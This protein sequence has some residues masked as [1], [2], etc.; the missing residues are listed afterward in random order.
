MK[1]KISFLH[2]LVML[3]TIILLGCEAFTE[4][5]PPRNEVVSAAVFSS[6]AASQSAVSGIYSSMMNTSGMF[7]ALTEQ[8]TGWSSDELISASALDADNQFYSNAILVTNTSLLSTFWLEPYKYI[9]NANLIIEG[10]GAST[11]VPI[12]TKAQ[13]LAEARFIR[14]LCY[15]SL[16]NLFGDVPLAVGTDYRINASLS[17]TTSSAV[18]DQ[19]VADLK[20]AQADLPVDF[21]FIASERVRPTRW[22]ATALLAR[23]YLYRQN[24]AGAE[25]Q[26]SVVIANTALFALVP[27]VKN[28]F[29]K[30]SVE[31]IWQLKPVVPGA[32]TVQADLFVLTTAP[33]G[34]TR[35]SS[36]SSSLVSSFESGDSRRANWVGSVVVSGKT[37]FYPWKN[38]RIPSGTI[39]E[40][41]TVLRLAEQYLIRAEARTRSGNL[42]GALADLNV[43]RRRAGLSDHTTSDPAE[44]LSF[45]MQE[46]RVELFV[47]SGHRWFD[48]KRTDQATV[49]LQPVKPG[50]SDTDVLY[51]VPQSEITL[52]PNLLPQNKG[53]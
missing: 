17:R 12:K 30:N 23:V 15:F 2:L 6:E 38:K 51:P 43:I 25:E 49:V 10:L 31:S 13:L 48:L 4:I 41:N 33:D 9:Y 24:C 29:L 7:N 50:W 44:L 3:A 26:S 53:Y 11:T 45:I 28:V 5:D 14:A 34:S 20:I 1:L 8:Y 39:S 27:D 32:N 40:Y 21:S 22:A 37:Y 18:Y 52:D 35:K 36:L 42:T 16:T 47:E 46:R 19:I